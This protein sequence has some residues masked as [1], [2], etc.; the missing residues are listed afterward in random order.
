MFLRTISVGL[1]LLAIAAPSYAQNPAPATPAKP[2]HEVPKPGAPKPL[3]SQYTTDDCVLPVEKDPRYHHNPVLDKFLKSI[4]ERETEA[5]QRVLKDLTD[6]VTGGF[7]AAR[8]SNTDPTG[9]IVEPKMK[10][11][12]L[13]N[14]SYALY[15]ISLPP[16]VIVSDD[17]KSD[18]DRHQSAAQ[19]K[20]YLERIRGQVERE[21]ERRLS[22]EK[23][24]LTTKVKNYS[25]D[26]QAL[27]WGR[28]FAT[29]T[30]ARALA[31]L[32]AERSPFP[33]LMED[34][35]NSLMYWERY[36]G[37]K[38]QWPLWMQWLDKAV[39]AKPIADTVEF[40]LADLIQMAAA[41]EHLLNVFESGSRQR[42]LQEGKRFPVVQKLYEKTSD[43]ERAKMLEAERKIWCKF[44]AP[45]KDAPRITVNY[46][47]I[48]GMPTLQRAVLVKALSQLMAADS[49]NNAHGLPI[50]IRQKLQVLPEEAMIQLQKVLTSAADSEDYANYRRLLY[51]QDPAKLTEKDPVK[52]RAYLYPKGHE[53]FFERTTSRGN[54]FLDG[55]EQSLSKITRLNWYDHENAEDGTVTQICRSVNVNPEEDPYLAPGMLKEWKNLPPAARRSLFVKALRELRPGN[56]KELEKNCAP[57]LRSAQGTANGFL[58]MEESI[59]AFNPNDLVAYYQMIGLFMGWKATP[60]QIAKDILK[61]FPANKSELPEITEFR[62]DALAEGD[63]FPQNAMDVALLTTGPKAQFKSPEDLKQLRALRLAL[64]GLQDKTK[65]PYTTVSLYET[66]YKQPHLLHSLE[67]DPVKGVRLKDDKKFGAVET[68]GVVEPPGEPFYSDADEHG[69][70]AP[71]IPPAPPFAQRHREE[72]IAYAGRMLN[73]LNA[74]KFA[75]RAHLR[76]AFDGAVKEATGK[77]LTELFPGAAGD[78]PSEEELRTVKRLL[79]AT[80]N[81][82]KEGTR[83]PQLDRMF[84]VL[85]SPQL[86][87]FTTEDEKDLLV[88]LRASLM[89]VDEGKL[90]QIIDII[91][92]TLVK[93]PHL[94]RAIVIADDKVSLDPAKMTSLDYLQLPAPP[95]PQGPVSEE[96]R[97]V[98]IQEQAASRKKYLPYRLANS[99]L[100][101]ALAGEVAKPSDRFK[102]TEDLISFF[103]ERYRERFGRGLKDLDPKAVKAAVIT[104]LK[105]G[106]ILQRTEN[107]APAD[108]G[109]LLQARVAKEEGG[110]KR[111]G[112]IFSAKGLAQIT[113][114]LL[115]GGEKKAEEP[116]ALQRALDTDSR[117]K[118]TAHAL[119]L[120]RNS[121]HTD[122]YKYLA[123]DL[124]RE[125]D[126]LRRQIFEVT[127]LEMPDP[128]DPAAVE[129]YKKRITA[130]QSAYGH[131]TRAAALATE[132]GYGGQVR[133]ETQ[134]FHSPVV[135]LEFNINGTNVRYPGIPI[136]VLTDPVKSKNPLWY[137][138]PTESLSCPQLRAKGLMSAEHEKI[139]LNL[140]FHH[141]V[142]QGKGMKYVDDLPEW[143]R[144]ATKDPKLFMQI[145]GHYRRLENV[146]LEQAESERSNDTYKKLKAL[147][148]K[149]FDLSTAKVNLIEL[150]RSDATTG[151]RVLPGRLARLATDPRFSSGLARIPSEVFTLP[152]FNVAPKPGEAEPTIEALHEELVTAQKTHN[153]R[154]KSAAQKAKDLQL[155]LAAKKDAEVGAEIDELVRVSTSANDKE[156][157][158]ARQL[159]GDLQSYVRFF[160][161]DNPFRL[162]VVSKA[163]PPHLTDKRFRSVLRE[164]PPDA[165]AHEWMLHDSG[166][167]PH[168][169]GE[170]QLQEIFNRLDLQRKYRNANL[171]PG[172]YDPA[173]SVEVHN[174]VGQDRRDTKA[175]DHLEHIENYGGVGDHPFLID[176]LIQAHLSRVTSG[177]PDATC[178]FKSVD[179]KLEEQIKSIELDYGR[180]MRAI[181]QN[182]G[183][184][185]EAHMARV[186]QAQ[187]G[188]RGF[189]LDSLC[190]VQGR[191]KPLPGRPMPPL[192]LW[193][194]IADL[195][196]PNPDK[197]CLA[198]AATFLNGV[199][200]VLDNR[201]SGLRQRSTEAGFPY[202]NGSTGMLC[203]MMNAARQAEDLPSYKAANSDR[204]RE[205]RDVYSVDYKRFKSILETLE[206]SKDAYFPGYYSA[207]STILG[208][209]A[210]MHRRHLHPDLRKMITEE[211][212]WTVDIKKLRKVVA[213]LERR[214][215]SLAKYKTLGR[216][217]EDPEAD[218]NDRALEKME[219][220]EILRSDTGEI[221]LQYKFSNTYSHDSFLKFAAQDF[222][223]P[224]GG[225]STPSVVSIH[226]LAPPV[227]D[228]LEFLTSQRFKKEL[229]PTKLDTPEKVKAKDAIAARNR[230]AQDKVEAI[231][232][233]VHSPWP[234]DVLRIVMSDDKLRTDYG[235]RLKQVL[236]AR[237]QDLHDQETKGP[238]SLEDANEIR[239]LRWVA[240]C[241][242]KFTKEGKNY[243]QRDVVV[244]SKGKAYSQTD[245]FGGFTFP[246]GSGVHTACSDLAKAKLPPGAT[247]NANAPSI[248]EIFAYI[249]KMTFEEREK[250]R[251]WIS[252]ELRTIYLLKGIDLGK[253]DELIKA[254]FTA[255][256][257]GKSFDSFWT[258][259]ANKLKG[260]ILAQTLVSLLWALDHNDKAKA[261]DGSRDAQ[262]A[263]MQLREGAAVGAVRFD[264][265][266]VA[267]REH[268]FVQKALAIKKQDTEEGAAR[269]AYF[270]KALRYFHATE[271]KAG[272]MDSLARRRFME[273]PD[274]SIKK[275]DLLHDI[276]TKGAKPGDARLYKM[277]LEIG[278]PGLI[279]T[280]FAERGEG[281][282]AFVETTAFDPA[283]V[284]AELTDHLVQNYGK[285]KTED[286][287]KRLQALVQ[288][289]VLNEL[290]PALD[291]A[292]NRGLEHDA[293]REGVQR[294]TFEEV[295]KRVITELQNAAARQ[296]IEDNSPIKIQYPEAH[297]VAEFEKGLRTKLPAETPRGGNGRIKGFDSL[298]S[299]LGNPYIFLS[300]DH[301]VARRLSIEKQ[302]K[303][304][305][306][307]TEKGDLATLAHNLKEVREVE[308]LMAVDSSNPDLAENIKR[309]AGF[310]IPQAVN[311]H[312]GGV[313]LEEADVISQDAALRAN[314]LLRVTEADMLRHLAVVKADLAGA[315]EPTADEK[316]KDTMWKAWQSVLKLRQDL[317]DQSIEGRF[318]TDNDRACLKENSNLDGT[319]DWK[320]FQKSYEDS[321]YDRNL[322]RF[323]ILEGLRDVIAHRNMLQEKRDYSLL[324]LMNASQTKA[325]AKHYTK[326]DINSINEQIKAAEAQIV[327]LRSVFADF[328]KS[329][330]SVND[331]WNQKYMLEKEKEVARRKSLLACLFDKKLESARSVY[332]NTKHE[333]V[334]ALLDE[335]LAK[336]EPDPA[337]IAVLMLKGKNLQGAEG[338]G[339][340]GAMRQ[341]FIE[342]MAHKLVD[343]TWTEKGDSWLLHQ[344]MTHTLTKYFDERT[345]MRDLADAAS[346][347][348]PPGEWG[349]DWV[350]KGKEKQSKLLQM[351]PHLFENGPLG[352]GA[353]TGYL[354]RAERDR[355]LRDEFTR[356]TK[357]RAERASLLK[358]LADN[359]LTVEGD[360]ITYQELDL[361][362]VPQD[363][364]KQLLLDA[365]VLFP[366]K[367]NAHEQV[368]FSENPWD[369]F[370]RE[371]RQRFFEA[372]PAFAKTDQK[373]EHGVPALPNVEDNRKKPTF[374]KYQLGN[375]TVVH[376]EYDPQT[377]EYKFSFL[378]AK[379]EQKKGTEALRDILDHM[380]KMKTCFLDLRVIEN[381]YLMKSLELFGGDNSAQQRE[382][383]KKDQVILRNKI[384]AFEE[385]YGTLMLDTKAK[386]LLGFELD[387]VTGKYKEKHEKLSWRTKDPKTDVWKEKD[388]DPAVK[389]SYAG[390]QPALS[391]AK[392][393]AWQ[394]KHETLLDAQR[395]ITQIDEDHWAMVREGAFSVGI[396]AA[397]AMV[398]GST[399]I[400]A[401]A[402]HG[403]RLAVAMHYLHEAFHEA[404]V[405]YALEGQHQ[406]GA[407]SF[408]Y[409]DPDAVRAAFHTDKE[410]ELYKSA[411]LFV[412]QGML[413]GEINA[414]LGTDKIL[415][416]GAANVADPKTFME[417]AAKKGSSLK[418]G[419]LNNAPSA[420]VGVGTMHAS[421]VASE[422][423]FFRI[424]EGRM[425]TEDEMREFHFAAIGTD[426]FALGMDK[427]AANVFGGGPV[428][429]FIAAFMANE[430]LK[431]TSI[432]LQT[433]KEAADE[434]EKLASL[435]KSMAQSKDD[436]VRAE[437]QAQI[438]EVQKHLAETETW[439]GFGKKLVEKHLA[440]GAAS[441][442]THL[443]FASHAAQA[444]NNLR[445]RVESGH[446]GNTNQGEAPPG[447]A[448][449]G[450]YERW[451]REAAREAGGKAKE[452][453]LQVE[454]IEAEYRLE[455][456]GSRRTDVSRSMFEKPEA[457]EAAMKVRKK[458]LEYLDHHAGE[459]VSGNLNLEELYLLHERATSPDITIM[460][461]TAPSRVRTE[462]M[463]LLEQF[464]K[465]LE[466]PVEVL[467]EGIK[468]QKARLRGRTGE[469]ASPAELAARLPEGPA[470]ETSLDDIDFAAEPL[471][472]RQ[473]R[474]PRARMPQIKLPSAKKLGER[475]FGEKQSDGSRLHTVVN[476]AGGVHQALPEIL[477][478][479]R[480]STEAELKTHA[481]GSK[482][483][484]EQLE[485][486]A[487]VERR[488]ADLDAHDHSR[489]MR[490]ELPMISEL[491]G[492][493]RLVPT[494]ERHKAFEPTWYEK[495]PIETFTESKVLL[496]ESVRAKAKKENFDPDRF[497][498]FVGNYYD[499]T[500]K[501][502][503]GEHTLEQIAVAYREAERGGAEVLADMYRRGFTAGFLREQYGE[504]R[505][506]EM[507]KLI[508]GE[509]KHNPAKLREMLA[510]EGVS[511]TILHQQASQAITPEQRRTAAEQLT[512]RDLYRATYG[513]PAGE[514]RPEL[515]PRMRPGTPEYEFFV[516]PLAKAQNLPIDVFHRAAAE[517]FGTKTAQDAP[518]MTLIEAMPAIREHAAKL[519][520]PELA[521]EAMRRPATPA[522]VSR[523]QELAAGLMH[524]TQSQAEVRNVE[525]VPISEF[526][527]NEGNRVL[528]IVTDAAKISRKPVAPGGMTHLPKKSWESPAERFKKY[529]AKHAIEKPDLT[530]REVLERFQAEENLGFR[531]P[532]PEARGT[533][534]MTDKEVKGMEAFRRQ[535]GYGNERFAG[536]ESAARSAFQDAYYLWKSGMV[537]Q[538]VRSGYPVVVSYKLVQGEKPLA[539]ALV[540]SRQALE[541]F[542]K[543]TEYL[544]ERA[545]FTA[546]KFGGNEGEA[547]AAFALFINRYRNGT[548]EYQESGGKISAKSIE[549]D[550]YRARQE[551]LAEV[552]PDGVQAF[553]RNFKLHEN[554]RR[555]AGFTA[556]EF[557]TETAARE[558]FDHYLKR[559]YKG[560]TPPG[561]VA[562]AS[563]ADAIKAR[564]T[565]SIPKQA[566]YVRDLY[567]K[568]PNRAQHRVEPPPKPPTPESPAETAWKAYKYDP[569]TLANAPAEIRDRV[570]KVKEKA[571][572]TAAKFGNAEE[573][574]KAFQIAM[575]LWHQG[576]SI[577]ETPSGGKGLTRTEESRF[578][579]PFVGAEA[580]LGEFREFSENLRQSAGILPADFNGNE[581]AAWRAF[582]RA[583][584]Q[585]TAGYI[586]SQKIVRDQ[587]PKRRFGSEEEVL[588]RLSM[589]STAPEQAA[590]AIRENYEV[591]EWLREKTGF[592]AEAYGGN[593]GAARDA[594]AFYEQKYIEGWRVVGTNGRA[595][596]VKNSF[597]D[598]TPGHRLNQHYTI[599]NSQIRQLKRTT[600]PSSVIVPDFTK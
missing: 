340:M 84:S 532:N 366:K 100:A 395:T 567:K 425:P 536:S 284:R 510:D 242:L 44:Y 489:F 419:L 476:D 454:A 110:I 321:E 92:A 40:K 596:W 518:G 192:D 581:A 573:E 446:L 298:R 26:I 30:A 119:L 551:G 222:N 62:A 75:S 206:E 217:S 220:G 410:W 318:T 473:R 544:R 214:R 194:P 367:K 74:G 494:I 444:K 440:G 247:F 521:T 59:F 178:K 492:F 570:A 287:S 540:N 157:A 136:D 411:A 391:I 364:L 559:Y 216:P 556:E 386:Y 52:L 566:Q 352:P 90:P 517:F 262:I 256:E 103:D 198:K 95:L 507:L 152:Q 139:C 561:R 127:K 213:A 55:L 146:G 457:Y 468:A 579:E 504:R 346:D 271:G 339:D 10:T 526:G 470:Q 501:G 234:D 131:Y 354:S 36:A 212:T 328:L 574:A 359:N 348:T 427:G 370:Q 58:L 592:T 575:N 104:L 137:S 523:R 248:A 475:M 545:G 190:V 203:E 539:P 245:R 106:E 229:L 239:M 268:A 164:L 18:P 399:P 17:P 307:G 361:T 357:E 24:F 393:L 205:V 122:L 114:S 404:S 435:H 336:P 236:H 583:Q 261:G 71:P 549:W 598:E 89:T 162:M 99:E 199:I 286:M 80:Q 458:L 226:N 255:M 401:S 145:I 295:S 338:F 102:K 486:L 191:L 497:S 452:A 557:G 189:F 379:E 496:E 568:D 377:S 464:A 513:Y 382:T 472:S 415:F 132:A 126:S 257:Q 396:L 48:D 202:L 219:L 125:G 345:R 451:R 353:E 73:D 20:L 412:V 31:P 171:T 525:N 207:P 530:M 269:R 528:G 109:A 78:K 565:Q 290:G 317:I 433:M 337:K 258:D 562:Q 459:Y 597:P 113:R 227:H 527:S 400:V 381:S 484:I 273:L 147:A 434:R 500:K 514:N 130:L 448:K 76:E 200:T 143:M 275:L 305:E 550:G 88:K 385:S 254:A 83:R 277:L 129:A 445:N 520:I 509:R 572:Y 148:A 107:V 142:G 580:F 588:E 380:D 96:Q 418:F 117:L 421:S 174:K 163:L 375:R 456:D 546:E 502:G 362:K 430:G 65:L 365:R 325:E 327:N 282:R 181:P 349:R 230:I 308:A 543:Y 347:L 140:K 15:R 343:K 529:V 272:G 9:K 27:D 408:I 285:I 297:Q 225:I 471:A 516:G 333:Q 233:A 294:A 482:E 428:R 368:S 270:D 25:T 66:L 263:A 585:F 388:N 13:L 584:S 264:P 423:F 478:E 438:D 159:L 477:R 29:P 93:S 265:K 33:K 291:E 403:A 455:A 204:L 160:P 276:L 491:P 69:R 251:D 246:P 493:K 179:L 184:S 488:I 481:P 413:A 64:R 154:V 278:D 564:P 168:E 558:A 383:C 111:V 1:C 266:V 505:Y 593:I 98:A 595:K 86:N 495:Y 116:T 133:Q 429:K 35:S 436:H 334:Q 432:A 490:F 600:P 571:G 341:D 541:N 141:L 209:Q 563:S 522:Q 43:E 170:P 124:N 462:S 5:R 53:P 578:G 118:L 301:L 87:L 47:E 67:I 215:A 177:K 3:E 94:L 34:D 115:G 28:I 384:N 449:G 42:V 453:L 369:E 487:K 355:I 57:P 288:Y 467:S 61:N 11:H 165:L 237:M 406:K 577:T 150:D 218:E 538:E 51:E 548:T 2:S 201:L 173:S 311:G 358:R 151:Y 50:E 14:L 547:R 323:Q 330:Q 82:Q 576:F 344:E 49:P 424:R 594:Y 232:K 228:M 586:V 335:E 231:A 224:Y 175:G 437:L 240:G 304:V 300:P 498:F 289:E 79:V 351:A 315:K 439:A 324:P 283:K 331:S 402:L 542:H 253:E 22:K 590:A 223:V 6:Y 417:W 553:E 461:E 392:H 442:A 332:L 350:E 241:E 193:K 322:R 479:I 303:E 426:M 485:Q 135:N 356:K 443:Y 363:T 299:A 63:Q 4:E 187:D 280:T 460:G 121:P 599:L 166:N 535:T 524:A 7:I 46:K 259:D 128:N 589:F 316:T 112:D 120:D 483:Y 274:H 172:A 314:N 91:N 531:D 188:A 153:E 310:L 169:L 533:A 167:V 54:K 469:P 186:A 342:L 197:E 21:I 320:K 552:T 97:T 105:E 293:S 176:A 8:L 41:R 582:F 23:F 77:T 512:V 409:S 260:N 182:P 511:L 183:E 70:P 431:A 180:L 19:K 519:M 296:Y 149:L 281:A 210:L 195:T 68:P 398:P 555:Q 372:R 208:P 185:S 373:D 407:W 587:G 569:R 161:V 309:L 508:A 243:S 221:P 397:S 387:P 144:I 235:K 38:E 515:K 123:Q 329:E 312:V 101:L 155:K 503:R 60:D 414:A 474:G 313:P 134:L 45:G 450:T 306:A 394:S 250:I 326:I 378:D 39:P 81:L 506:D 72:N 499:I 465:S 252:A 376:G 292:L 302:M 156:S 447:Q 267:A 360:H 591:S 37:E 416:K 108:F 12:E 560:E 422:A 554:F 56:W 16:T 196:G 249:P 374:S 466:V 158:K 390:Y 238:L 463:K 389:E 534:P 211:D 420:V 371:L 319:T 537:V 244:D 441:S 480:K 138:A 405:P 85:N 32:I 279:D